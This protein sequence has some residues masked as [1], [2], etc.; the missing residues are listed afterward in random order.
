MKQK[1]SLPLKDLEVYKA[2]HVIGKEVWEIVSVWN[3]FNKDTLGKQFVRAADSISFN[4]CEGYGR[5]HYKENKNFCYY[6][7][8][9]LFETAECLIKAK[10]RDLIPECDYK[11]I[12]GDVK[13]LQSRLNN[14]IDS[15]GTQHDSDQT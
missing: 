10:E 1:K 11:R 13:K 3:F 9:S 12:A 14:Y 5:Y 8:G 6:S 2:A 7:R 15:I 4:I